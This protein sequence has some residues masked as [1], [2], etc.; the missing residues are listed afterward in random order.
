MKNILLIEENKDGTVGGSH[1]CLLYLVDRID[2]SK[3]KPIVVFYQPN[4]WVELFRHYAETHVI[5]FRNY[6]AG[7][8]PFVRKSLNAILHVFVI[9]NCLLF[10]RKKHIDL[11]HLNNSIYGAYDR[12][13]IAAKVIGIPCITH[14]RNFIKNHIDHSFLS[15]MLCNRYDKIF[16]VSD[17]IK[18]NLITNGILS[19]KVV[20]IYDGIDA[21][22]YRKKVKKSRQEIFQEFGI[23]QDTLLIG[24]IG[25]I[26]RWK[27][28]ELL[29][30]SLQI[31]SKSF[32]S[33][34]CLL[35]GDT[36]K[37]SSED[38]EYKKELLQ[39]IGLF[40]LQNK[41]CF[42]GFRND[43][44]D[45]IN[46]LDLQINSS[47]EPDP[48]PHVILE[49]M[50]LGK[51]IIA[52]DLGGATESIING[53]TGFTFSPTSTNDFAEIIVRVLLNN[54]LR[55]TISE[56]SLKGVSRFSLSNMTRSIEN[57]YSELLGN[58]K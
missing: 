57:E 28:Q 15:R 26:R 51:V 31:V 12:W 35:I 9:V 58:A 18:Q 25:N 50:A 7:G 24:N 3:F 43:V 8:V 47:I 21:N 16:A 41:I 4:P 10:L 11:I 27:G 6:Y 32:Q 49:G 46:A 33:F 45:L 13:L 55:R 20:T 23:P 38:S 2:K 34:Y 52:S 39:K 29:I 40:N 42:T 30:D 14:E 54:E 48:F 5:D 22:E 1:K 53:K 56:N 17:F 37:N 19:E 44:P 36:Q